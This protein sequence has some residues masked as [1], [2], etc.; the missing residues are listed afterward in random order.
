MRMSMS[1]E[2]ILH[3]SMESW[4][5]HT[6]REIH[7][8]VQDSKIIVKDSPILIS[9]SCNMF[10]SNILILSCLVDKCKFVA[11]GYGWGQINRQSLGYPGERFSPRTRIDWG[12]D[13]GYSYS[14]NRYALCIGPN[15]SAQVGKCNSK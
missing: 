1:S 15:W 9:C 11:P 5:F 12:C 13:R 14:G 10:S 6:S 3:N 2:R 4:T 8:N 7:R